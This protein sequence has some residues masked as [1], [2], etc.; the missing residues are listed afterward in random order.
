M[1]VYV[2]GIFFKKSNKIW[3]SKKIPAKHDVHAKLDQYL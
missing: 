1:W 2:G 3:Y